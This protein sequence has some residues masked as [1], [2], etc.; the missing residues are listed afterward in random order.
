[1]QARGKL[2]VVNRLADET[3]P[4][5]L[6][7]ADNP[8][9]GTRGA[10]RSAARATRT[11]RSALDRLRRLPLVPRDGARVVRGRSTAAV[12][13]EHFV[14]VKV[15]REERPDL[16]AVYMDAGRGSVRA[17]RLADDRLPDAGRR[18]VLRRHRTT[19]PSPATGC[20]ASAS[21]STRSRRRGA[22]AATTSAR[23]GSA[24][25]SRAPVGRAAAVERPAHR[26]ALDGGRAGL[27]ATF[28]PTYGGWGRA[29]KFP[30]APALEFLLRRVRRR[31]R[32]L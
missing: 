21:C 31:A 6:Q 8:S 5:L 3:S 29:P 22:S 1:M 24:G 20:R 23:R 19:C 11:G 13:N 14:S 16:D 28:E 2:G 9:T 25:R 32:W 18:A 12:M 17:R 15:D 26:L 7:H 10:R 27:A 30:N 4:Y